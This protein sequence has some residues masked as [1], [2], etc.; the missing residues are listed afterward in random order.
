M[1]FCLKR[2]ASG[3][4]RYG[5][6]HRLMAVRTLYAKTKMGM[7]EKDT[8]FQPVQVNVME[9]PADEKAKKWIDEQLNRSP[10]HP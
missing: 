6:T 3:V 10:I 7:M 2:L 4:L 5:Q 1:A 8:D 9:L